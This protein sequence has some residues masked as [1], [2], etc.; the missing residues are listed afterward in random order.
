MPRSHGD[1]NYT[2]REQKLKAQIAVL[3]ARNETLKRKL[4]VEAI[5]IKDLRERLRAAK[6]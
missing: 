1:K 5:K 6:T 3:E 2:A 4:K